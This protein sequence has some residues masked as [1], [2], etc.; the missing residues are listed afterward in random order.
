MSE[1]F[2]AVLQSKDAAREPFVRAM[3]HAAAM[4][5]SGENVLLSVGPALEPIGVKQRK[6]LH[7]AVLKQI[8]EQVSLG[9]KRYTIDLWKEH[10]RRRFLGDGGFRWVSMQLPGAKK[11]TPRR[12]AISTEELGVR[13]YSK[14]TNEVIDDAISELNVEFVFTSEERELIAKKPPH[15]EGAA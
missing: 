15:H 6:F 11:A 1:V 5:D 14:F 12:I 4:L 13:A 10:Y 7:G 9:G 8:S 2:T 3:N